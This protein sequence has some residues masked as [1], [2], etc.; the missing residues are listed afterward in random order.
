MRLVGIDIDADS[1]RFWSTNR[2]RR[3]NTR[4][5]AHEHLTS[6]QLSRI[7]V[8]FEHLHREVRI[9][10]RQRLSYI[11][12]PIDLSLIAALP[13]LHVD[14]RDT[15]VQSTKIEISDVGHLDGIVDHFR[16]GAAV[17]FFEHGLIDDQGS[18]NVFGRL[19]D[20]AP[21]AIVIG[22]R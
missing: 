19:A 17:T 18:L 14:Y 16:S 8:N 5:T 7:L 20:V 9:E 12:I 10:V 22:E 11:L 15:G 1:N 21:Q 6:E 3:C 4:L 2:G 13:R